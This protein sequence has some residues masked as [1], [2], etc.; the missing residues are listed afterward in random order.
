MI[1]VILFVLPLISHLVTKVCALERFE[2]K[3]CLSLNLHVAYDSENPCA[4][5]LDYWFGSQFTWKRVRYLYCMVGS[6]NIVNVEWN[7]TL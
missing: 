1:M 7:L 2:L 4:C 3:D 6:L 5:C